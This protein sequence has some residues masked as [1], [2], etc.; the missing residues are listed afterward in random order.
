MKVRIRGFHSSTSQLNLTCFRPLKPPNTEN[1]SQKKC[2]REAEKW[3]SVSPGCAP[4]LLGEGSLVEVVVELDGEQC[5]MAS[6]R[7]RPTTRPESDDSD[8]LSPRRRATSGICI[9]RSGPQRVPT[10]PIR[11]VLDVVWNVEQDSLPPQHTRCPHIPSLHT[12]LTNS[13]LPPS[14]PHT[15]PPST[16]TPSTPR[17]LPEHDIHSL[18]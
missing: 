10:S 17:S 1:V 18:P 9:T 14:T 6:L 11:S 5:T 8:T 3:A 12:T 15:I 4:I 7:Q 16:L 13:I 2:S